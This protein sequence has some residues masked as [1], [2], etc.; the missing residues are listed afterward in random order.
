[1]A[2]IPNHAPGALALVLHEFDR[3]WPWLERAL[4]RGG[5]RHTRDTIWQGIVTGQFQFWPYPRAAGVSHVVQYPTGNVLRLWLVGGDLDEVLAREPDLA[6]WGRAIGCVD[7][8]LVGRHG[9]IRVLSPLGYVP[10]AVVLTR[11]L[12]DGHAGFAAG[13]GSSTG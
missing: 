8:E 11:R 10:G 12:N 1:M 13:D 4:R 9:W 7:L 2:A 5:D 3:C 6:A